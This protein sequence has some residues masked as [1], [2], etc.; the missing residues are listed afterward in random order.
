[1]INNETEEKTPKFIFLI[2]PVDG[3]NN[4]IKEIPAYA[5]ALCASL[6][7]ARLTESIKTI[8]KYAFYLTEAGEVVPQYSAY[9]VLGNSFAKVHAIGLSFDDETGESSG[10]EDVN[11][12]DAEVEYYNLQG[13]KVENP[14]KGIYI[15]KQGGKTS[16]V[17]L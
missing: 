14:E 11:A 6:K 4:A 12:E 10:I 17:V 5:F 1:M 9:Y 13:V 2:D 16:K 15:M 7:D 3:T 8:N